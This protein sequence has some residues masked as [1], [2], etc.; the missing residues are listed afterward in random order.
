MAT[1]TSL[2]LDHDQNLIVHQRRISKKSF[3]KTDSLKSQFVLLQDFPVRW[4]KQLLSILTDMFF[5]H[6]VH[7]IS[8]GE[9]EAFLEIEHQITI[10]FYSLSTQFIIPIPLKFKGTSRI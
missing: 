5:N 1:F 3:K 7:V 4:S 2:E 9:C 6:V 8:V 10:L